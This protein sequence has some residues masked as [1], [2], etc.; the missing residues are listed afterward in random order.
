[1]RRGGCFAM[2]ATK[3]CLKLIREQ[4]SDVKVIL[5]IKARVKSLGRNS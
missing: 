2:V 5:S 4:R 3:K 1:M